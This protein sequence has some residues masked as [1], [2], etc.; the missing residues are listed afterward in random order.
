MIQLRTL[1]YRFLR[2]YEYHHGH[3][4]CQHVKIKIFSLAIQVVEVYEE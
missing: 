1:R 3:E 4:Y 2:N